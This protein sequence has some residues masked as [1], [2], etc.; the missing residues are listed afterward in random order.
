MKERA[1]P[2]QPPHSSILTPPTHTLERFDPLRVAGLHRRKWA[3]PKAE[4]FAERPATEVNF[5]Q[6]YEVS[7]GLAFRPAHFGAVAVSVAGSDKTK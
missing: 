7:G 6:A 1:N 5:A 3:G 2:T 4:L